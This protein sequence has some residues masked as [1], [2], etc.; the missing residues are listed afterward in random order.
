MSKYMVVSNIT[1]Q[2]SGKLVKPGEKIDLSHL[3][4]EKIAALVAAGAIEVE[5][6]RARKQKQEADNG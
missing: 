2:P 4:D 3:T 1:I 5:E 6:I